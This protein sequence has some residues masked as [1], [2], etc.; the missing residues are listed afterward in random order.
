MESYYSADFIERSGPLQGLVKMYLIKGLSGIS[1][2]PY[3]RKKKSS[4]S[5]I[6]VL[7]TDDIR[8]VI[9]DGGVPGQK[10]GSY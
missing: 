10:A 6:K 8:Y 4:S 3:S 1:K 2:I 9:E 5:S 7:L